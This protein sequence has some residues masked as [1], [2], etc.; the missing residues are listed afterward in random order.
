MSTL[1][2]CVEPV[3]LVTNVANS[4]FDTALLMVVYDRLNGTTPDT[5]ELAQ[6]A[7]ARFYMVYNTIYSLAPML[8]TVP[9]ARWAAHRQ[10][11]LLVVPLLGYLIGRLL[12]FFTHV[13]QLPIS[14]M[15]G[16]AVINGLTGGFPAYWS[17][18][19]TYTALRSESGRRR[20]RLNVLEVTSGMAGLLGSIV[21]GHF[22]L[23]KVNN[24][25]GLLL[26]CLCLSLY[27]LS[28]LYAAV[29]LRYPSVPTQQ[30]LPAQV[31]NPC[32][33]KFSREVILFFICYILYD[34]GMT[35]GEN[36]I[37]LYVLKPPLSWNSVFVGYGKA[38]SFAMFLTSFLGVLAFSSWLSDTSLILMGIISNTAGLVTMAFVRSTS[39]YFIEGCEKRLEL[40]RQEFLDVIDPGPVEFGN[41]D[42]S[43]SVPDHILTVTTLEFM[44]SA[45]AMMLF[46]YIPMPTIRA[47]LSQLTEEASY[48]SVFAWLQTAMTLADVLSTLAFNSLYITFLEWFSSFP[49]LLAATVSWLATLPV[50][51]YSCGLRKRDDTKSARSLL[52]DDFTDEHAITPSP[53]A[54]TLEASLDVS[55]PA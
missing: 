13:F 12:L 30:R 7:M 5:A 9:L 27:S 11:V 29:F 54:E 46:S 55:G 2:T 36:V 33:R 53:S 48:G 6:K 15:Y 49:L 10:R 52:I 32:G 41:M 19:N 37:A 28:L 18:V 20:L 43:H 31:C 35:G 39:L 47:R 38:A 1:L 23:I 24:Q 4:L 40:E 8:T 16:S 25:Q 44:G 22:F 42:V 50:L 17:G 21:S 3:V 45:R 14:V 34:F 26:I 51:I